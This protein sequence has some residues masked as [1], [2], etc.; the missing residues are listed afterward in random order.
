LANE[1]DSAFFNPE[2]IPT[3]KMG[4]SAFQVCSL[5]LDERIDLQS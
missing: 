2:E 3:T 4:W 5:E 1:L